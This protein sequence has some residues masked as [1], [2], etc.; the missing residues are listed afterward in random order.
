MLSLHDFAHLVCDLFELFEQDVV[1]AVHYYLCEAGQGSALN[2]AALRFLD[3]SESKLLEMALKELQL[4]LAVLD[5]PEDVPLQLAQS[6]ANDWVQLDCGLIPDLLLETIEDLRNE[7]D[8]G[9]FEDFSGHA[10][11]LELLLHLAEVHVIVDLRELVQEHVHAL[12]VCD[13]GRHEL[14]ELLG[15]FLLSV[16]FGELLQRFEKILLE[17]G[18]VGTDEGLGAGDGGGLRP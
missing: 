6:L 9:I 2:V 10:E 15:G 4:F 18:D 12:V 5:A 3:H 17:F 1:R 13:V 16:H 11:L 8:E 7:R 14:L